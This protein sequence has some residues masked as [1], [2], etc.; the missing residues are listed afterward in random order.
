M[1]E[2]P[3]WLDRFPG[4]P[5]RPSADWK[6]IREW[7]PSDSVTD[8]TVRMIHTA[9]RFVEK[10]AAFEAA[11]ATCRAIAFFNTWPADDA[12]FDADESQLRPA[13]F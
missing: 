1:G 2:L 4:S 12:Y 7:P 3:G 10:Q 5:R 6:G 8:F 11:L 13:W 9:E